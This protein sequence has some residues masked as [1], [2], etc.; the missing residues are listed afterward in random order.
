MAWLGSAG[1]N[2]PRRKAAF[3][4]LLAEGS[5]LPVAVEGIRDT[6][7]CVA[8]DREL[9][10]A[11]QSSGPLAPRTE[12]LAPLDNLLWDRR[13]IAALFGFDYKWEVY[14]P[15]EQRK[16][17]HYVLPILSGERFVGRAEIVNDR[18]AQA[19]LVKGVWLEGG[20]E[21]TEAVETALADCWERFA[22]FNGCATICRNRTA[23]A[24]ATNNRL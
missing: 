12:L 21:H 17:G 3:A 6:L 9:L 23:E 15:A 18:K 11:A 13:L 19:L 24:N 5:I 8:S 10:E 22:R 7:Y 4:A 2:S 20:V 14:T 1:M 16:F